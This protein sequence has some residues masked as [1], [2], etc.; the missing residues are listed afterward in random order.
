MGQLIPNRSACLPRMTPGERRF[1][2][3]LE[4]KLD[5]DYLCWY[6]VAVGPKQRHPDFIVLHPNLGLLILEVKDWKIDTIHQFD[7]ASV[8]LATNRGL[9]VTANP[10]SQA[11]S[12]ARSLARVSCWCAFATA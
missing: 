10:L 9:A 5:S 12:Y 1:A 7:K 8:T 4:D 6:D 2:Q 11:R 3:R